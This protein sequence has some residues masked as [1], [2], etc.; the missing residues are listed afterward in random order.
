MSLRRRGFTAEDE[1][2]QDIPVQRKCHLPHAFRRVLTVA[3]V[4]GV[5]LDEDGI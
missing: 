5:A 2:G 4:T 3:F 1:D